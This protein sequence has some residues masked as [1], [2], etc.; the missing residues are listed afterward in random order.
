MNYLEYVFGFNHCWFCGTIMCSKLMN[1]A[2][3]YRTLLS[4]YY[5]LSSSMWFTWILK[6]LTIISIARIT[7]TMLSSHEATKYTSGAL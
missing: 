5:C 4:Y 3:Y 1:S 7:L 2:K 6:Q